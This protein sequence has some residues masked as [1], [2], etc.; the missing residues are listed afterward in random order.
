[1][2]YNSAKLEFKTELDD[3]FDLSELLR[4]VEIPDLD[5]NHHI[6]KTHMGDNMIF[7][8]KLL[9]FAPHLDA[10]KSVLEWLTWDRKETHKD[11][12]TGFVSF[13]ESI[14]KT[15]N[16]SYDFLILTHPSARMNNEGFKV[17]ETLTKT[18]LDC[19]CLSHYMTSWD[20]VKTV[21]KIGDTVLCSITP[22]LV[23]VIGFM[24]KRNVVERWCSMYMRPVKYQASFSF[25]ADTIWR[26]SKTA[27]L[28]VPIFFRLDEP[29][30]Q[31]YYKYYG[32]G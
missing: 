4:N 32:L 28:H 6:I 7:N 2:E 27:M 11:R 20:N 21:E 29:R 26:T 3:R 10:S 16:N 9:Y 18:S 17:L 15:L 8:D 14:A 12:Y 30:Y 23:E 5:N 22:G 1:M 31:N 13:I 24:I 19:I 25:T